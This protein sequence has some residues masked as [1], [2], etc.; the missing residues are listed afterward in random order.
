MQII[1][2]SQRLQLLIIKQFKSEYNFYQKLIKNR[3]SSNLKTLPLVYQ[4]IVQPG[5][6]K[7]SA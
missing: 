4:A 2:K 6:I 1:F 3:L 7:E 5:K